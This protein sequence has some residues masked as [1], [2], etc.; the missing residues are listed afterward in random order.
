[1]PEAQFSPEDLE[2][3]ME[4]AGDAREWQDMAAPIVAAGAKGTLPCWRCQADA[5]WERRSRNWSITCPHCGWSAAG[6]M[7][8]R[9]N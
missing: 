1:M 6:M 2:R 4:Q 8:E 3:L 9:F 7:P 5:P